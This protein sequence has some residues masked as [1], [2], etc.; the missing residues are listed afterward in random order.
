MRKRDRGDKHD[1]YEIGGV[2]E[3]WILDKRRKDALF[4][5]RGEDG[6]FHSRQPIDGIYTSHVL[7][8]LTIRVELF[9][10][11][12]LPTTPEI[13]KMVEQMLNG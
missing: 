5:V 7:P 2:D 8:K 12:D 6:L 1:E 4:Y 9:W 11:E 3:Y 13:I 10:Q